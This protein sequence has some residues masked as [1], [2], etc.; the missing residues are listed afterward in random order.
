MCLS[1]GG[2][3]RLE[4]YTPFHH[5]FFFF[6]PLLKQSRRSAHRPGLFSIEGLRHDLAFIYQNRGF[7]YILTLIAASSFGGQS[8]S[9]RISPLSAL[10]EGRM[11][12]ARFSQLG[13]QCELCC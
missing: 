11:L 4:G 3:E 9:D 10:E 5:D 2:H 7:E 13:G 12:L 8:G 6:G 1:L